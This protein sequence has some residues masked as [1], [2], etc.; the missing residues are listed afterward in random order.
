MR[1]VVTVKQLEELTNKQQIKV[2]TLAGEYGNCC[3]TGGETMN[4]AKLSDKFTI[5]K[6]I[7]LLEC[8]NSLTLRHDYIIPGEIEFGL[9]WI[10]K[11]F[12]D[13]D[14]PIKYYDAEELVDALWK[15]IKELPELN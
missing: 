1:Q 7:E 3:H 2:A 12:H 4:L 15:G 10:V 11:V 14:C 5:G 13:I 9:K 8:N 6:M